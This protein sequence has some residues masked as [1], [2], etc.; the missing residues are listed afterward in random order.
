MP[1]E[2]ERPEIREARDRRR[3]A[4]QQRQRELSPRTGARPV[5]SQTIFEGQPIKA[6]GKEPK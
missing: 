2:P 4:H 6:P 1:R 3:R 5:A